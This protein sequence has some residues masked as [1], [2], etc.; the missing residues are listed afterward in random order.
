[1]AAM[2]EGLPCWAYF[3]NIPT[4][5][6]STWQPLFKPHGSFGGRDISKK[7]GTLPTKRDKVIPWSS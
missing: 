6:V 5:K 7:M 4:H 2:G 1:M 3:G